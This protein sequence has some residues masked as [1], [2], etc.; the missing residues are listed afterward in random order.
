MAFAAILRAS[1]GELARGLSTGLTVAAG[2][3]CPSCNP[4][5]TC[6]AAAPCPVLACPNCVCGELTRI[7]AVCEPFPWVALVLAGALLL[8]I[9]FGAG[10]AVGRLAQ[11]QPAAK[12]RGGGVWLTSENVAGEKRNPRA[13]LGPS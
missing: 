3:R 9:G 4:T 5:L 8:V 6:S 10:V 2:C 1:G 13:I 7:S 11:R 12:T